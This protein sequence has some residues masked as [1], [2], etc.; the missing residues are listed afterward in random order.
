MCC[1]FGGGE[2][3]RGRRRKWRGRN[4]RRRQSLIILRSLNDL[5]HKTTHFSRSNYQSGGGGILHIRFCR[6]EAMKNEESKN[7]NLENK[8]MKQERC[9]GKMEQVK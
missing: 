7:I 8:I 1:I 3:V 9:D 5:C 4:R 6:K 2:G